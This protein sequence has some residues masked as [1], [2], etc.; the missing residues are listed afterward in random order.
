MRRLIGL[1]LITTLAFPWGPRAHTVVNRV[2]VRLLSADGPA[3]LKAHEDWIAHWAPVPDS[4]R[5]IS[6][7][8][9]KILEDPNHGWFQEQFSFLKVIPRSRYEFVLALY[10]EHNR[11]KAKD[12]ARAALTNVRWTGTLPYA[13]MEEFEHTRVAMR[14]YRM[15]PDDATRQRIALE[16]STYIG[17]LGHYVADAAMP[18]HV[19]VHHDGW[20]GPNPKDY[21]R[22]PRVHGRFETQFVELIELKEDDFA[23]AVK[24]PR[25]LADPWQSI[26]D[27]IAMSFSHVEEVYALD[28]A[29]A[30]SQKDHEQARQLV[31][32]LMA[33]SS[34][35]LRDLVHTAWLDSATRPTPSPNPIQPTHP[36]FNPATG[37]APP[38]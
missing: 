14:R 17:R 24:A 15:A 1:L 32:K 2:A 11:L 33:A 8:Y 5:L 28:K 6:E 4:W 36:N 23:S 38:L 19:S 20:V 31:Y 7:P 34:Q 37:S 3:F 13:A 27:H 22:D 9:S 10:D 30:Y 12:P 26:M 18:L 35:L 29:G 16:M 21:T 25:H